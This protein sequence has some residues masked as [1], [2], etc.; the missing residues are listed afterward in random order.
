MDCVRVIVK[1][2]LSTIV[3]VKVKATVDTYL[4]VKNNF[5][6][7]LLSVLKHGKVRVVSVVSIHTAT[8]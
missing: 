1:K 4:E 8:I 5:L 6:N 2:Y 3:I 7:P